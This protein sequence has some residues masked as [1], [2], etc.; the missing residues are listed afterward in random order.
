MLLLKGSAGHAIDI[1]FGSRLSAF[2]FKQKQPSLLL[3]LSCDLFRLRDSRSLWLGTA[4]EFDEILIRYC[5]PVSVSWR[6]DRKKS[7][8][9]NF[10][11]ALAGID[12]RCRYI[13]NCEMFS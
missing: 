10:L 3:K 9:A 8:G 1:I 11:L 2:S 7:M 5:L 4:S 13:D 6:H 12:L